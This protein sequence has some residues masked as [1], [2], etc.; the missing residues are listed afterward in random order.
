MHYNATLYKESFEKLLY[1]LWYYML[2]HMYDSNFFFVYSQNC[3]F[4]NSIC[5]FRDSNA[6]KSNIFFRV[7]ILLFQDIT[8][9]SKFITSTFVCT[10][11][12]RHK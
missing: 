9:I 1:G 8:F 10:T 7:Y 12:Y 6:T 2:L 5:H 11:P 4:K 3:L